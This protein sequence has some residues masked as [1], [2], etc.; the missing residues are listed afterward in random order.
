MG[1]PMPPAN[2]ES[3]DLKNS[4]SEGMDA[5]KIN[6]PPNSYDA[7]L[8]GGTFDRLHDGHRRLLK[9]AAELARGRVFVG[10][11][12]GPMLENKELAHLIEP[13]EKRMEAAE[14]YIKSVKPELLVQV[15]P[16]F[17]IDP[18][19]PPMMDSD[20][21]AIIVSKE[22]FAGA[23]SVNKR[24]AER[25]LSQLKL[26]VV[27]LVI[28][29]ENGEKLSSTALRQLDASEQTGKGCSVASE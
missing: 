16:M 27:D 1:E 4:S 11:C 13:L 6:S 8:L 25:G 24:R 19:G 28:E 3:E 22:T 18:Y 23:L 7:V 20:R 26:E 2:F 10:V 17:H 5:S 29:G 21:D 15:E 9:A 14:R 12:T